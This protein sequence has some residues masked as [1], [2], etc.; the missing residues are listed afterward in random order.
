M[1]KG[2]LALLD[3]SLNSVKTHLEDLHPWPIRQTDKVMARAVE[4]VPSLGGVQVKK[5]TR[6]NYT[7]KCSRQLPTLY[8]R[9]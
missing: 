5:D 4:Q 1:E 6:H 8:Y 9:N 3:D 2:Y 7:W